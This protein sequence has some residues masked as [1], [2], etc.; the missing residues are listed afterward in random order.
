MPLGKSGQAG[1]LGLCRGRHCGLIPGIASM[2]PPVPQKGKWVLGS[3]VTK[4]TAEG[5]GAGRSVDLF[6]LE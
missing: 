1:E 5:Q 6:P 2:A 4:A 3:S